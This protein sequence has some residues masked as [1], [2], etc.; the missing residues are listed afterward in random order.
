MSEDL[1]P[2]VFSYNLPVLASPR[3]P[4]PT[5][6]CSTEAR[7]WCVTTDPQSTRACRWLVSELLVLARFL[8]K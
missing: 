2:E 6:G 5:E 8:T 3:S 4:A 1:E 7:G